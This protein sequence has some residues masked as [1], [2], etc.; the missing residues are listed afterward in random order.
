MYE[1][2]F[3][4]EYLSQRDIAVQTLL[5][6]GHGSSQAMPRSTWQEWADHSL[7]MIRSLRQHF[8][9][10]TLIGFSTGAP[11]ALYLA[12]LQPV[13]RLI[14]LSP[15]IRLRR[16]P[17]L[18]WPTETYLNTLG[19]LI[20][21]VPR[22]QLQIRDLQMLSLSR[23]APFSR[24][25]RLEVVRSVLALIAGLEPRLDQIRVPTLIVQPRRDVVVDPEGAE[26]L[27][28]RLGSETKHLIWLDKSYHNLLL[29]L[30]R[31]YCFELVGDFVQ[32]GKVG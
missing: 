30:E 3:L 25:F 22:R 11:L 18:I 1:F 24:T 31:D 16:L 26:M 12:L 17:A 14:L 19:R 8:S 10:L 23:S 28:R 29:D 27:Y 9:C 4:A 15:F 20:S 7:A 5:Y 2:Q 32:Y 13:Q 6:P 21:H